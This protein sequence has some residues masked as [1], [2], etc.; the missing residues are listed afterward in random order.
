M[1]ILAGLAGL[2]LLCA[3]AAADEIE[4]SFNSDAVRAFYV[5]DF[6]NNDLAS[7]FGVLTD[8]DKGEVLSASL[9]L[10]G[11]ASDG[12]NPLKAGIGGRVAYVDGDGFDQTGYPLAV[13]GY[14]KYTF[15][16]SN[17]LSVRVDAWY[18]PDV[19]TLSDLD[20]YEDFT[21]RFAYNLLREADVYVGA[22]YVNG[23]YDNGTDVTFDNGMHV[24]FHIRF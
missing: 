2:S 1:R 9:L 4:L 24:G 23:D 14:V 8:S 19:L 7:D 16:E 22:R 13:G 15:A 20:T 12:A 18:A 6:A 10:T 3:T 5:H 17:R 11:F 21:I